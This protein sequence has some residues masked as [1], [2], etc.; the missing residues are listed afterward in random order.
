MVWLLIP[1]GAGLICSGWFAWVQPAAH[2]VRTADLPG[3]AGVTGWTVLAIAVAVA[4]A[5]MSMLLGLQDSR[6]TL[7]GGPWVTLMLGFG[8]LNILLLSAAIWVAH[9]VGPVTSDAATALSAKPGQIYL[10]YLITSG[11]R[12]WFGRRGWASPRSGRLRRSAGG[13]RSSCPR[14]WLR[15]TRTMLG[16]L[17]SAG[18]AAEGLVLVRADS[19]PAA[20]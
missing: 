13:G 3:M 6:G 1:A 14:T 16:I 17:G 5:L 11:Y 2:S 12:C 19:V 7:V 20:R 9:L 10:P 18:G 8:S 15:S 4:L